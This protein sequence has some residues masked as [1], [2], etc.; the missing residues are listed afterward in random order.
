MKAPVLAAVLAACA[1]SATAALADAPGSRLVVLPFQNMSGVDAARADLL[2]LVLAQLSRQGYEAVAG[3]VVEEVLERDRMRHLD[4]LTSADRGR[5]LGELSAAGLL[6]AAVYTYQ[7]GRNPIVGLSARLVGADGAVV[8]WEA[9]GL[10]GN[11]TEGLFAFGREASRQ[12]LLR[13]AVARLFRSLPRAGQPAP[14]RPAP[15]LRVCLLPLDNFTR[16]REGP[17]VVGQLLWRRLADG[18]VFDVVEPADLR[19]AAVAERARGLTRLDPELLRRVGKRVGTTL[20]LYG[21]LYAYR[22]ASSQGA[23]V[24]PEVSVALTLVDVGEARVLRS[25]HQERTG[26]DY[27]SLFQRG[28]VG[29]ATGLADRVAAELAAAARGHAP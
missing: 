25:W 12:A 5:L 23:A 22:E 2:P 29:S 19:A 26:Q 24:T 1:G 27:E 4:S 17:R 21:A 14:A 8:W 15:A 10:S 7:E 11:D 28:A 18:Q 20:F 16:A 13:K 6:S 3:E 9:L